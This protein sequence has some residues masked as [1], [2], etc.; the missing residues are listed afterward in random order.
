MSG[1]G[2]I[3]ILYQCDQLDNASGFDLICDLYLFQ[4][5]KD[6]VFESYN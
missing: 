6:R 1:C 4:I 2:S 5:D 3:G